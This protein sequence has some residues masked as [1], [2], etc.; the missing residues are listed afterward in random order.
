MRHPFQFCR[1]YPKFG[2][3]NRI[4]NSELCAN[5]SRRYIANL[6]TVLLFIFSDIPN[7][8]GNYLFFKSRFLKKTKKSKLKFSKNSFSHYG[9]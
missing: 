6:N 8:S 1:F 2:K 4:N 3:N 7:M 9:M 5:N